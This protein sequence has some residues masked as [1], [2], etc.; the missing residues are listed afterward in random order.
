MA[1]YPL[2]MFAARR[3]S[4]LNPEKQKKALKITIE[5]LLAFHLAWFA[6]GIFILPKVRYIGNSYLIAFSVTLPGNTYY[7]SI[8]IRY[9]PDLEE[10]LKNFDGSFERIGAHRCMFFLAYSLY[11]GDVEMVYNGLGIEMPYKHTLKDAVIWFSPR[12]SED[13]FWWYE[14]PEYLDGHLEK[15]GMAIYRYKG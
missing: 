3:F 13:L 14:I 8:P 1:I 6:S 4:M 10:L 12:A 9:C 5:A 15:G 11:D 2:A 7:R